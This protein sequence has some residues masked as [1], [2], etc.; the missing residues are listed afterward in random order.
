MHGVEDR[1]IPAENGK[2][3]A[4]NIPGAKLI[5]YPEAGHLFFIEK[6]DEV[7]GAI[8]DFL[9]DAGKFPQF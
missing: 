3:L 7:N 9:L 8:R 6:A 2:Y 5:L 1:L 4:E